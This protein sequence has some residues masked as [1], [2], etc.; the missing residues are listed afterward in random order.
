MLKWD[1][2]LFYVSRVNTCSYCTLYV[3][4][5]RH[6]SQLSPSRT[7][8]S[9]TE[10]D[11]SRTGETQ[12][13]RDE[14]MKGDRIN[15]RISS[16]VCLDLDLS[17]VAGFQVQPAQDAGQQPLY[18]ATKTLAARQVPVDDDVMTRRLAALRAAR[19]RP[20]V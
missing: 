6:S 9:R 14:L 8:V 17:S 13:K 11:E 4:R 15:D 20:S 16:V 7:P 10:T 2:A 12:E 19:S 3:Y 1:P 5:R 18:H